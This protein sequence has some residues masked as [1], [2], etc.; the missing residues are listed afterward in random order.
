MDGGVRR[1]LVPLVL[2]MPVVALMANV[3]VNEWASAGATRWRIPVTGFDPRDPVRGRFIA[4]NYRWRYEGDPLICDGSPRCSLCLEGVGDRVAIV[5]AGTACVARV[6]LAK[7]GLENGL[8]FQPA[9]RE[10]TAS[11]RLWVSEASAPLLEKQL[12]SQPMVAVARLTRRG[13]LIADRL[14]TGR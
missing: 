10:V 3:G 13:R 14:E 9:S 2:A 1:Y 4:F 11:T 6:D 12:R 7:S 5:P 8:T